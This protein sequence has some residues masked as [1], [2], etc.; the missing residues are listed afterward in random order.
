MKPADKAWICL[1]VGVAVYEMAAALRRWELLSEA[2]DR[3]RQRHPIAT[4]ST[5]VYLAGHLLR[6]WPQRLDPLHRL[7][8]RLSR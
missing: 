7:A 2:A 3:Y 4:H 6:R 8:S 1:F 5:V